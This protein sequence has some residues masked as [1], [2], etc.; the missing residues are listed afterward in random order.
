MCARTLQSEW[1]FEV[2][3][4]WQHFAHDPTA[5]YL[6]Y[7]LYTDNKTLCGSVWFIVG[8]LSSLCTANDCVM[9]AQCTLY[10]VSGATRWI[11]K[12]MCRSFDIFIQMIFPSIC[13]S[14]ECINFAGAFVQCAFLC[15]SLS[16]FQMNT[17][18]TFTQTTVSMT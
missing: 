11:Q 12:W 16:S 9:F 6:V 3:L 17:S 2:L 8:L 10:N 15:V 14:I 7:I 18:S 1:F 4:L 5:V 13:N